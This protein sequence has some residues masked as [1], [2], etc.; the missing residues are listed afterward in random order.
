MPKNMISVSQCYPMDRESLWSW[1]TQSDK[2]A[3]W[4]GPFRT[5]GERL[6]VTMIQEETQPEMEGRILE[7]EAPRWLKLKL[8]TDDSAWVISLELKEEAM[9]SSLHLEQ[10]GTGTPEDDWIDAGWR[11]YLDCLLAAINDEAMPVFSDY[12]PS[13]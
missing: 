6:F 11:F 9:G 5:E 3:Q 4:F 10:A 2:T 12:A 1:L 8:G 13:A 7:Q